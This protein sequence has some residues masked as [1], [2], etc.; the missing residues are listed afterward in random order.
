MKMI[1][2]SIKEF[3]SQAEQFL[4]CSL[5]FSKS[6]AVVPYNCVPYKMKRATY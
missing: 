5:I 2:I 3:E 6:K 4:K 1:G